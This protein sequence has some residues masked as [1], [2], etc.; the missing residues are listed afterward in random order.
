M[1]RFKLIS[2]LFVTL[3]CSPTIL[4]GQEKRDAPKVAPYLT[5]TAIGFAHVQL[6]RID[7]EPIKQFA[8]DYADGL[9]GNPQQIETAI[10]VVQ[11]VQ[12]QFVDAGVTNL[13]VVAE[14]ENFMYGP[15]LLVEFKEGADIA[16]ITKMLQ[17]V[18]HHFNV[19]A[20]KEYKTFDGV[21]FA[22]DEQILK[23]ITSGHVAERQMLAQ[24]LASVES[25]PLQIVICPSPDQTRAIREAVP[26]F[27]APFQAIDG[28][29][30]ARGIQ[31]ISFGGR[32]EPNTGIQ[33]VVQSADENSAEVLLKGEQQAVS[34]M[35]KLMAAQFPMPGMDK[36]ADKLIMHR[37]NNRLVLDFSFK[38][39]EWNQLAAMLQKPAEGMRERADSNRNTNNLKRF[40]LAMHNW[41]DV[42]KVLPAHANYSK[43]GKPLLSWRVHVLPYLDQV[44]LYQKFH[45]NEPWDSKHNKQFISQIP[46]VFAVPGSAVAKQGRT[47]YVFPILKDGSALTIPH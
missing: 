9:G 46:E 33:V 18:V 44:E 41:H 5:E 35:A 29:I 3:C 10:S 26:A 24:A 6:D 34:M 2:L 38:P 28:E 8:K 43:D 47:G 15:Y 1:S 30:L 36:I 11:Q 7:L 27:P 37:E 45:L 19:T 39:D 16:E 12:K 23:N 17:D 40:G 25:D 42:Y 20:I 4:P 14:L 21:L 13:Y 32:L 31:Y 22:G